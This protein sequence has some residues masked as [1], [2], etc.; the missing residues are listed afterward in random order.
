MRITLLQLYNSFLLIDLYFIELGWLRKNTTFLQKKS[1]L[2]Q[3]L[4]KN[5]KGHFVG[6]YK[7][8][9]ITLSYLYLF[10]YLFENLIE[11][12]KKSMKI[13]TP[14]YNK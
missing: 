13:R 7:F 14:V 2:L 12:Y 5:K 4:L 11:K 1:L 8:S 3:N 6:W 10:N 9:H